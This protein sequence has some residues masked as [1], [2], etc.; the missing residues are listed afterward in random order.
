MT[1]YAKMN[2]NVVDTISYVPQ[3]G[4]VEVADTLF[5]EMVKDASDNFDY[6]DE[7]K[8]ENQA[9]TDDYNSRITAQASGNTKLLAL[10]LTQAEAT[11]LTGY[12]P[13]V[14]E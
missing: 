14:A 7:F 9:G 10:G 2:G 8:A 6:T 4:Y 5:P 3:E 13:P 1:K 11:A 12:T